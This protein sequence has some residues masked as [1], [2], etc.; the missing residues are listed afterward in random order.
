MMR[1]KRGKMKA[2]GIIKDGRLA[3][4]RSIMSTETKGREGRPLLIKTQACPACRTAVTMLDRAG[5]D[6]C[7]VSD[8]DADYD[9]T[10]ARYGVRH[11]PTLVIDPD[12]AWHALR[13]TEEIR[14][15]L[16]GKR[17]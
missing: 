8:L 14:D 17:D 11:V 6:Y 10:V 16:R 3:A 5:V 1:G 4:E 7:V 12:G 13:G 2:G 15:F 9:V